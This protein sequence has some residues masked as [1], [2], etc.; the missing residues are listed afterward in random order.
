MSK[1]SMDELKA[2]AASLAESVPVEETDAVVARALRTPR[3]GRAP[4]K[5]R[6]TAVGIV[7][8]TFLSA[9]VG[10]AAAAQNAAPGDALY[11]VDR[12]Y[13]RIA[14]FV[15]ISNPRTE[16]RLRE[17][18]DLADRGDASAALAAA[19]AALE[20]LSSSLDVP[21]P[22]TFTDAANSVNDASSELSQAIPGSQ[23]SR[24]E[25]TTDMIN[26]TRILLDLVEQVRKAAQDGEPGDAAD[27]ARQLKDQ[28]KRVSD[29][30]RDN[31]NSNPNPS[32]T[33]GSGN[34]VT[35]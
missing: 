3:G 30:A 11:G 29:T 14:A 22:I 13:E 34:A 16:E 18:S 27:A 31:R 15:G 32:S 21:G 28:A 8:S 4:L 17:A 1:S 7:V 20:A 24:P 10:L 9:N 12:A 35:P 25:F 6:L 2:F 23:S 26:E 19:S 5:Q 33:N